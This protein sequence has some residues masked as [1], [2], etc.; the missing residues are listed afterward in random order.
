MN[1]NDKIRYNL[2]SANLHGWNPS[3]FNCSANDENLINAI[4]EFQK[5]NN[6]SVDGMVGSVTY[7]KLITIQS[8]DDHL[9]S[10]QHDDE[11]KYIMCNGRKQP[12]KW[13]KVIL[14]SDSNGLSNNS[15]TIKSSRNP[16]VF[17]T[18]WDATLNA[19][20]C[21]KI[22][23][24]RGLSVHFCLDNDGTIYQLMD[25]KDIAWH[26]K[27]LNSTSIGIEISNAYD[28]KWQDWYIKNGFGKRPIMHGVECHGKKLNDFLGFYDV[29]I[30]ALTSLY[31]AIH[32]AHGIPLQ[33]PKIK[34]TVDDTV[35]NGTFKGFCSHYHVTTDKIDC[36]GLDIDQIC[37]NAS[38]LK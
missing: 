35:S 26:C 12:I 6:L 23:D 32:E 20:T 11:L 21:A 30:E 38:N 8:Q 27:G 25:T 4:M 10:V 2:E 13:N 33:A 29:Q 1:I 36:A 18:H 7:R 17:V 19:K 9:E 34:D 15:K 24:Q 5:E 22:L 37:L 31:L 28:L 14:W 16:S 3:D